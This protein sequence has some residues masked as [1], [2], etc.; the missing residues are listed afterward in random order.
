MI[1]AGMKTMLD[2]RLAPITNFMETMKTSAVNMEAQNAA[3]ADVD[4]AQFS[5][6]AEFIN[7]VREDMADLLDIAAARGRN[8]TLQEV[9]DRACAGNPEVSKLLKQREADAVLLSS[10]DA[11]DKKKKASSSISGKG[12]GP[13]GGGAMSLRESIEDAF[14]DQ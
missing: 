12:G 6:D 7:E 2:E 11:A 3:K 10:A 9:Y 14:D 4:V 1:N 8:P 13:K 5:E